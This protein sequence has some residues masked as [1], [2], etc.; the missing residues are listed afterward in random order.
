MLASVNYYIEGECLVSINVRQEV[1]EGGIQQPKLLTLKVT[2][3]WFNATKGFG[4]AVP[5]DRNSDAFMH[6]SVLQRAGITKIGENAQFLCNIFDTAK[7]LQVSEILDVLDKGDM[8][9]PVHIGMD[10]GES[11]TYNIAGTVKWFKEDKGFGFV[12]PDDGLKD[13]F[14]HK[15]CLERLGLNT[16]LS[17][18][19]VKMTV[20]D[21]RQ[22]REAIKFEF[23][24]D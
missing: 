13:I 24:E 22:G 12:T 2:L 11:E 16:L 15:S 21:V 10:A 4:F 5:E 9:N 14:I 18:Q 7:G 1:A 23:F 3:K 19:R 20:K 6:I 17:G 8:A